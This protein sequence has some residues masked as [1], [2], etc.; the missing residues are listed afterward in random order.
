MLFKL[1]YYAKA[2]GAAFADWQK[3]KP[4]NFNTRKPHF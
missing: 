2:K 1:S 4:R 3:H